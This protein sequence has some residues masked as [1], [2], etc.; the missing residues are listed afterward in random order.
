[1]DELV[2]M[3]SKK[4]GISEKQARDAVNTVIKFAKD[5]LPGPIGS[6]LETVLRGGQVDDALAG[7][8]KGLGDLMGKDD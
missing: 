2:K 5:K 8:T 7:L 1:M 4:A 3:V 6:Q